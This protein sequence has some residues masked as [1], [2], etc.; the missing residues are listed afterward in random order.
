MKR[1]KMEADHSSG[2]KQVQLINLERKIEINAWRK[3][4]WKGAFVRLKTGLTH[5]YRK[6]ERNKH[7]KGRK[8][9]AARPSGVRI[10]LIKISVSLSSPVLR[11]ELET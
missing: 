10:Q 2:L 6:K 5:Q 3:G 9:E 7:V 4:R 1:G 8:M 11:R